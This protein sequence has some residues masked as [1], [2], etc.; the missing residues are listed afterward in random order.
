[1]PARITVVG[2]I[3][4]DLVLKVS[5]LPTPGETL[6]GD[7]I[8][9]IPGGKGANQAVGAA[10]PGAEVAMVGSVGEDPFG[11]RLPWPCILYKSPMIQEFQTTIS[12]DT[13]SLTYKPDFPILS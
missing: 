9:L 11:P 6:T 1:M 2:S 10:R 5:H 8:Q 12:C 3:N 13:F 7:D 4:I